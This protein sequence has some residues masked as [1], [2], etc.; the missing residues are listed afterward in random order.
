MPNRRPTPSGLEVKVFATVEEIEQAVRK[1]Q[2]RI[3]DVNTFNPMATSMFRTGA[4]E[5]LA[6]D[7]SNSIREVFGPNSPEFDKHQHFNLWGRSGVAT[8][9]DTVKKRGRS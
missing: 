1:L 6:T 8:P 4:D 9:R 7:I 3:G 5:V 2:R